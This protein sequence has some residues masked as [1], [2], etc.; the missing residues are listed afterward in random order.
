MFPLSKQSLPVLASFAISL[1]LLCSSCS[2]QPIYPSAPQSGPD[3][4]INIKDLKPEIPLFFTYRFQGKTINYFVLNIQGKVSSFLDACASCYSY[5][6]GYRCDDG[7]I[8]CRHCDMKFSVYKLEKG[9]GS[10]FPIKIEGRL[11]N[12]KYVIPVA[13]LEAEAGKF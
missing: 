1:L 6:R 7:T 2:R 11:E 3:I 4:V 5:K 9:L 10:C 12:G 8:E 13:V